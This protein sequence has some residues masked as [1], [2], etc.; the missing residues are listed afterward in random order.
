MG[1]PNRKNRHCE[2]GA[3]VTPA[4]KRV[5]GQQVLLVFNVKTLKRDKMAE[6]MERKM[7]VMLPQEDRAEAEEVMEFMGILDGTEK[8]EFL[9]FMRG[10]KFTKMLGQAT[11]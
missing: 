1:K 2:K 11:A 7:D 10:A 3:A 9:A 6:T 4:I 5:D 8:K